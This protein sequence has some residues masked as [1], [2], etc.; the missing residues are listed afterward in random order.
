MKQGRV[1]FRQRLDFG[2]L[3]TFFFDFIK[4]NWKEYSNIFL[5]YNG[6]F[7]LIFIGISYMMVTGYFGMISTLDI[8]GRPE[9]SDT[10]TALTIVGLI[11]YLILL[12]IVGGINFGITSVYLMEYNKNEGSQQ[13]INGK[14]V[15][16]QVKRNA[17]R[18]IGFM[19]LFVLIFILWGICSYI[20]GA[21]P[22]LLDM[23][24]TYFVFFIMSAWVGISCMAMFAQDIGPADALGVGWS[25]LMQNFWKGVGL[26][27]VVWIIL[28]ATRIFI[29]AIP[30]YI[31]Y[32][33][34]FHTVDQQAID[35]TG[36]LF[37]MI[38]TV[39]V[40]LATLISIYMQAITQFLNGGLFYS[41]QEAKSNSFLRSKIDQIGLRDQ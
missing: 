25:L 30:L 17:G 1:E 32:F 2:Q 37:S 41:L 6:I 40:A 9:E 5:R 10:Y 26:N 35:I 31:I 27:L 16:S 21:L 11:V 8:Y 7:M 38:W 28:F 14:Q 4:F 13:Q 15:W 18:L 22:W 3:N 24:L 23:A 36:L 29:M 12:L 33:I 34:L 19:S 20:F 39:F